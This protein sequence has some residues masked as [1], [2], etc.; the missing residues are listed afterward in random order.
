MSDEVYAKLRKH[1]D[2]MPIGYPATESGVELRL[3]RHLF[4]VEEAQ[5]ALCL[6]ALPEPL[7]RIY[8][9][10]RQVGFTKEEVGKI[11]D[12]LLDKGVIEGQKIEERIHYSKSIF[13]VG[14]YERQLKT[15]TKE[16]QEDFVQYIDEGFAQALHTKKTTQLRTIPIDV[17][18]IP[19][20]TVGNYDSAKDTVLKSDGPFA[21]M[22][23]I[24]RKG[25]DLLGHPCDQTEVR[26]TCL[27]LGKVAQS[28]I[29]KNMA[30]PIS[31][32]DMLSML[33]RADEEGM[34]LQPQ[35]S[36]E[37]GFIC[38]CCGCCCG[39]L[40][41]AK[42]FPR[43]AEY[44]TT[45]YFAEIDANLC[46]ECGT[47]STRC[48]MEALTNDGPARVLLDRCIGCGLCVSTCPSGAMKLSQKETET[49]PPKNMQEL[50]KR[51]MLE[52]FGT[53]GVA[54]ILGKKLLGMKI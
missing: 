30:R 49:I 5:V 38:C 6:S 54:K 53:W 8:R 20:R 10:S 9:R 41:S 46:I 44:F 48:Q 29:E 32:G 12:G 18:I 47:C 15:L 51:I 35:N 39:V 17:S 11:L 43:P 28:C 14:M 1:L 42:R 13:V 21:V 36:Q 37:P 33:E 45:N 50:Y 19:K 52:R 22:D 4:S 3:L 27:T 23:C 2:S 7:E 40:T 26:E 24:C 34:V 31:Q 25:M 16:F